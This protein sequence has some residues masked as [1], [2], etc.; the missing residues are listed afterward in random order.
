MTQPAAM[1]VGGFALVTSTTS[2]SRCRVPWRRATSRPPHGHHDD[3]GAPRRGRPHP[4]GDR[5]RGNLPG[6]LRRRLQGRLLASA[7]RPRPDDA[8]QTHRSALDRNPEPAARSRTRPGGATPQP[9]TRRRGSKACA[10]LLSTS[11]ETAMKAVALETDPDG[12]NS[13]ITPDARATPAKDA[14]C[15]KISPSLPPVIA[16]LMTRNDVA[17]IL[18]T[19][20]RQISN[21]TARGQIPAPVRV[22]GL[23]LRWRRAEIDAWIAAQ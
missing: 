14:P 23:G 7:S 10:Q 11:V 5:R 17:E 8:R 2:C 1:A 18:R 20:P 19:T 12:G 15:R 9:M 21:M 13:A 3:P 22:A 6:L 16:P 4:P